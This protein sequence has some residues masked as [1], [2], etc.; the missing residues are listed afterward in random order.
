MRN[1]RYRLVGRNS[2]YDMERDPSQER[3]V[4]GD[5]PEIAKE[6][7]AFYDKWFDNALPQMVNEDAPLTGHNTFHLLYWSQ[8]GIDI[9][10]VKQRASKQPKKKRKRTQAN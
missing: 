1:Q 6:M 7:N 8:Y 10:P 3:N 5:H 9:P 4:I 2:L